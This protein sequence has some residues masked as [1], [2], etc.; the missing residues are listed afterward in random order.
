MRLMKLGFCVVCRT[1][2]HFFVELGKNNNSLLSL[3]LGW[4]W[5]FFPPAA[6]AFCHPIYNWVC[7]VAD[8]VKHFSE[9]RDSE[10][11]VFWNNEIRE[12]FKVT[13]NQ[14]T[15]QN[16]ILLIKNIPLLAKTSKVFFSS[17]FTLTIFFIYDTYQHT[18]LVRLYAFLKWH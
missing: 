9:K 1:S 13:G 4:K 15:L 10:V 12:F 8:V 3:L 14:I 17:K 2:S 5:R 7:F 18:A 16:L 6:G 11:I